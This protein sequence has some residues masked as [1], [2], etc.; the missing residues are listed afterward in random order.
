[1][2]GYGNGKKNV[3]NSRLD[4]SQSWAVGKAKKM[5]LTLAIENTV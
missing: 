4:K 2:H 1:M 3:L 5:P